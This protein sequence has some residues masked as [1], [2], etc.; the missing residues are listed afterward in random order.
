M[1]NSWFKQPVA[2][3]VAGAIAIAA[4]TP[5]MAAPT[6]SGAAGIKAAAND[7]INVR[8]RGHGGWGGHHHSGWGVGAAV[9]AGVI[10]AGVAAAASRPYYDDPY[11]GYDSGPVYSYAPDYGYAPSYGY[12]PA[13]VYRAPRGGGCWVETDKDRGYG[14]YGACR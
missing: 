6:L 1:R 11:Y 14:Y 7:T 13:P 9:A 3:A 10:G 8:Y 5:V 4:A 2:M 12:A